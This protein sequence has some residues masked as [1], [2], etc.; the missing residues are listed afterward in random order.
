MVKNFY[1]KLENKFLALFYE[2]DEVSP[3]KEFIQIVKVFT[4]LL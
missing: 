1:L 4:I 3:E 2:L